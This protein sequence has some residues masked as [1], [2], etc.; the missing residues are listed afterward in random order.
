MPSCPAGSTSH[1]GAWDSAEQQRCNRPR[2]PRHSPR[3]LQSFGGILSVP[4][5]DFLGGWKGLLYGGSQGFG[6]LYTGIKA[7][8]DI[9]GLKFYGGGFTASVV[10]VNYTAFCWSAKKHLLHCVVWPRVCSRG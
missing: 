4:P 1:L 7:W 5:G 3:W 10:L 9:M 8:R 6:G 2:S